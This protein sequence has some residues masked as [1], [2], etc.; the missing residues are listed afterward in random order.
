MP[1]R[2]LRFSWMHFHIIFQFL[3]YLTICKCRDAFCAQFRF[4]F[5]TT[6]NLLARPVGSNHYY[7][8]YTYDATCWLALLCCFNPAFNTF[9]LMGMGQIQARPFSTNTIIIKFWQK[10]NIIDHYEFQNWKSKW[11]SD[12]IIQ[13]QVW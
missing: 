2:Q 7:I 11:K 1:K 8:A 10:I 13:H 12:Y 4:S 9:S 5:H 3:I 6:V